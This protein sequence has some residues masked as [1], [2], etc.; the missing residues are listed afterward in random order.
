MKLKQERDASLVAQTELVYNLFQ[1]CD[2]PKFI[3]DAYKTT[4]DTVKTNN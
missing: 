4:G 3:V 1:L 2:C